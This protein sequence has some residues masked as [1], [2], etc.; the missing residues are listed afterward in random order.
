M[1]KNA[2]KDWYEDDYDFDDYSEELQ[3][4]SAKDVQKLKSNQKQENRNKRA[5]QRKKAG[6]FY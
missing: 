5:K 2:R 1:A 6:D 3:K 4:C